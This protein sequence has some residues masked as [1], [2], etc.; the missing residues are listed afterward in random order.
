M[1]INIRPFFM[2]IFLASSTIYSNQL[3]QNDIFYEI[4][5]GNNKAVKA[6]LKTKPDLSIKNEQGQSVLHVAALRGDRNLVKMLIKAGVVINAIDASG[7]TALD[8]AIKHFCNQAIVFDLVKK[9]GKVTNAIYLQKIKAIFVERSKKLMKRFGI[10]VAILLPLA[11]PALVILALLMMT[12]ASIGL[13]I[14]GFFI[15]YV[16]LPAS[17]YAATLPVQALAI[18]VKSSQMKILQS[19]N[20]RQAKV[21]NLFESSSG[22]VTS[23]QIADRFGFK[24]RTGSQMCQEWVQSGFLEIVDASNKG[25]TYKLAEKYA[26]LKS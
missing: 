5:Q 3:I 9:G 7:Q 14:C 17:V 25:R 23:K 26:D 11:F 13:S 8:L 15:S 10:M 6:W 12:P 24:V 18:K 16:Q 2:A 19:V 20:A 21:L 4:A 1:K 22:L